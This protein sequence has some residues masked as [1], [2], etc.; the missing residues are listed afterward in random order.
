MINSS[1]LKSALDNYS[2]NVVPRLEE[3]DYGVTVGYIGNSIVLANRFIANNY[4]EIDRRTGRL[5][6]DFLAY[7]KILKDACRNCD[8]I[9]IDSVREDVDRCKYILDSS[10]DNLVEKQESKTN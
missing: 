5:I 4:R 9:L 10:L 1:D 2:I 7:I 8:V 3:E 6:T